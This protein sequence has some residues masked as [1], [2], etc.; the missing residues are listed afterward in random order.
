M[1][2]YGKFIVKS[3]DVNRRG[4]ISL[5]KRD[6]GRYFGEKK[7][8]LQRKLLPRKE[9]VTQIFLSFFDVYHLFVE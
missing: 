7:K 6:L 1:S 2:V 9:K 5:P 3:H 8:C 4:D